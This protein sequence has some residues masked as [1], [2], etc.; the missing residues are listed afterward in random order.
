MFGGGLFQVVFIY[1][2]TGFTNG[3]MGAGGVTL[4]AGESCPRN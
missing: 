4:N 2:G 1:G 3:G